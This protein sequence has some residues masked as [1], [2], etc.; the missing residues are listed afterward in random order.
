QRRQAQVA[1]LVG[2]ELPQFRGG[3]GVTQRPQG[4][5]DHQPQFALRLRQRRAELLG[6]AVLDRQQG[7]R[8]R[9]GHVLVGEQLAQ[10]L[11]RLLAAGDLQLADDEGLY[12][13]GTSAAQRE[14]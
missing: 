13:L 5:G 11:R 4:V 7:L 10:L 8:G 3:G 12:L 14:A 6:R 1:V 2:R 9:L